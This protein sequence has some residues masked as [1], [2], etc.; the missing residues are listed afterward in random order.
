[1]TKKSATLRK[2]EAIYNSLPKIEC[3]K[4][5]GRTNCGP[6]HGEPIEAKN[7]RESGFEIRR[8]PFVQINELTCTYLNAE[9]QCDI[10]SARPLI[11][12][13]W[14][15]AES[16][17]CQHGCVAERYLTNEECRVLMKAVHDL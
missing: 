7:I 17:K 4:L 15:V 6:I 13:I 5:C 10:Y 1:M 3:K 8:A 14:G 12:R 11:C 9:G 16:L 2:L